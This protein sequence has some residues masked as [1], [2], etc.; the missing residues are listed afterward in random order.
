MDITVAIDAMGGDHGPR[1]TVPAALDLLKSDSNIKIILVGL[2]DAIE[3][4]LTAN[5][6]HVSSRISIH[7]ASELVLMDESPQS[8]LK[9]KKDSSMRV[10][11]NLVK[12]GDASACVSA[13]NT[14]ALMATARFVLKTLPG[15][16]RPAIAGILPNQRG[17]T[18]MMDLGANA[19]CTPEHLLQFA[20]MGSV[21]VS[22]VEQKAHP[23]VGLL[24]IGSE[25]IKGNEVVKQTSEL[26]RE[27]HL[28]FFGNVE[29]DD[30]YKGTTDLVV[31]D[32]FVGNVALKTSEGLAHL[33]G[34][35][36]KEEFKR[37]WLTK[38]MA[39]ISIPVLKAF[40]R[41]LDPRCYNGASFLGLRGIVVKSHGGADA[42]A[43]RHAIAKAVEESRSGVLARI[44]QQLEIE[45]V[46]VNSSS[47]II[48]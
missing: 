31:C 1:V 44:T 18:Y 19:D 46:Q 23:T 39:L 32:G 22:C 17:I 47:S 11:I 14:G 13:G 16:D 48:N 21:L 30:I 10:A 20:I 35:F 37:N 42:F 4:E 36:L 38:I 3:A 40:K 41:R 2:T 6:S 27:S 7:H 12:S 43:F 25:D 45:H 8:A 34:G 15:I 26:L 9:N 5:N 24:N 29:G 33:M 28:N